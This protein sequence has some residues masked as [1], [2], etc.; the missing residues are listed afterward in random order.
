MNVIPVEN[1]P[2]LVFYKKGNREEMAIPKDAGFKASPCGMFSKKFN[3]S[4]TRLGGEIAS[5]SGVESYFFK[6]L[7]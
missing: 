3:I 7:S 1:P 4:V 5:I 2:V 6:D